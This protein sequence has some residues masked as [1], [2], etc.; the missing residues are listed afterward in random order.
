MLI[1]DHNVKSVA[2]L[3]D[4]VFAMYAG[5]RHR[6]GAARRRWSTTE[7]VRRVYLGGALNPAARPEARVQGRRSTPFLEVADLPAVSYNRAIALE[8][9]SLHAHPRRVRRRGR[10]L[11]GAGKTTL[12]NA[13]FRPRCL[14]RRHPARRPGRSVGVTAAAIARGGV[15]H[16]PEG[17]DLFTD[18]TVQENLDMGGLLAD[19]RPNGRSAWRGCSGCFPDWPSEPVHTRLLPFPPAASSRC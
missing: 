12:F 11:N 3:A 8:N 14:C 15:A 17:R 7:T 18:M 9:V 5:E 16:A 13:D 10:G 19:P 2:L 6:R 1:V 4:R